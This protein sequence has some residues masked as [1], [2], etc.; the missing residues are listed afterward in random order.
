[1][2]D[3]MLRI[4]RQLLFVLI[5]FAIVGGTATQPVGAAHAVASMTMAGMPC[6][7]SMPAAGPDH[8]KPIVPCKD[9]APDCL[10]LMGCVTITHIALP[11]QLVSTE[12]TAH[13]SVVEYWSLL[14]RQTGLAS[15]PEPNPP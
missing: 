4:L 14:H 3:L 5:A 13:V 1:M 10:K 7:L 8:G 6:G 9:V 2:P 11:A 12:F 15:T